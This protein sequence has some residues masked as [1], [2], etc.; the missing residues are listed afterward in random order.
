MAIVDDLTAKVDAAAE[1]LGSIQTKLSEVAQEIKDLVAN[2]SP[3]EAFLQLALKLDN[4]VAN[5]AATAA[6]LQA[7]DD[8]LDAAAGV[9]PAPLPERRRPR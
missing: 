1:A 6:A 3:P 9:D 5:L 4:H 2:Q 8:D 7:A